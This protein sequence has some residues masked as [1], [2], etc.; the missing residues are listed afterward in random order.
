MGSL[1]LPGGI[2]WV[3]PDEPQANMSPQRGMPKVKILQ[4]CILDPGNLG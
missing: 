2:S 1:M 4:C 3:S